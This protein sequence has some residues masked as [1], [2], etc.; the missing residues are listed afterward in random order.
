MSSLEVL[1]DGRLVSFSFDDLLKYHGR[2]SL[3]GVAHA[4]KALER[5]LP[6]LDGGSPPERREVEVETAFP[7]PGARDGFE[8]VT[9]AAS[10]D[11]YRL[12]PDLGAAG[13]AKAPEGRFVFRLGYR[14]KKVE[15]T[16]RDEHVSE[17]FNRLVRQDPRTPEEEE[18]LV[19]LKEQ[20]T[21]RFLELPADAVYDVAAAD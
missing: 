3:A 11:R 15:L 16:L 9:R 17:E 19:R 12:V 5:G 8:M 7:G 13:A 6:L 18:A 10:E 21:G 14:G 1:D 2:S 4:F 20:I